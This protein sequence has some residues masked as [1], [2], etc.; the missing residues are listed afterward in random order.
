MNERTKKL[1]TFGEK[2]S[3]EWPDY[4]NYFNLTNA[5]IPD[6]ITIVSDKKLHNAKTDSKEVWA[7]LHAWRALGQIKAQEA[8]LPLI[9]QFETLCHDDWALSEICKVMGMIGESAI[10]PLADY[11]LSK[12]H[13]EYSR[14]MAMD[15]LAEIAKS[16]LAIKSKILGIFRNYMK[17]PDE[18]LK[19]LNGLLI[20]QLMDLKADELIEEIRAIYQKD[21]LDIS[22]PGDLEDAE[23]ALG[24]RDFRETPKPHYGMMHQS[25]EDDDLDLYDD[26]DL[27]T[28][29]LY[30]GIDFFLEKYGQ[31]E[32]I[33]DVSELDG[34]FASIACAP[35][36]IM[37]SIWMPAIWGGEDK[38]PEWE[39]QEEAEGFINLVMQHYNQVMS[40]LLDD[41]YETLFHQ[42]EN[43]GKIYTIVDEWCEGFTRALP[44]WPLSKYQR[45]QALLDF[46]NTISLFTTEEGL[47]AIQN[48]ST[49]EIEKQQ[50]MI[51]PAL[52]QLHEHYLAKRRQDILTGTPTII[53]GEPKVG[54]NDSC[55]CG[56]GK[57]FKKCCLH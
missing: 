5:D 7:P 1:L 46:L 54:R 17:Q 2:R 48:L 30:E 21:C 19:A 26:I 40:D 45:D 37:P 52:R 10:P 41:S 55:P 42:R 13:N 31:D 22:I 32:S 43:E 3:Q 9:E 34:F 11:F 12:K 29:F 24:L 16:H 47:K 18:T 49:N 27:E 50:D 35:D 28:D 6:L 51:E 36:T 20:A 38:S 44:L 53:R 57:K 56:S 23:I 8:T 33:L 39:D 15:S 25:N 14:V 4:L